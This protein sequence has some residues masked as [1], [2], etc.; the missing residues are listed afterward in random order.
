MTYSLPTGQKPQARC[1]G[2]SMEEGRRG[3]GDEEIE[4]EKVSRQL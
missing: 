4:T 3:W 1:Y 2:G